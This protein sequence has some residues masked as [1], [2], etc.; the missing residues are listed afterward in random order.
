MPSGQQA[1]IGLLVFSRVKQPG[2]VIN[3]AEIARIECQHIRK[4]TGNHTVGMAKL[5]NQ[6]GFRKREFALRKT[7][8]QDPDSR[9]VILPV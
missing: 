8:R 7:S 5:E 3:P 4:A 9:T 1:A 6:T 2:H